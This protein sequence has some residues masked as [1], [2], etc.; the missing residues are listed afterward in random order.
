MSSLALVDIP[1]GWEERRSERPIPLLEQVRGVRT[2]VK[3]TLEEGGHDLSLSLL[4]QAEKMRG[5]DQGSQLSYWKNLEKLKYHTLPVSSAELVREFFPHYNDA[6]WQETLQSLH[7]RLSLE[8]DIPTVFIKRA[9]HRVRVTYHPQRLE[10]EITY[11]NCVRKQDSYEGGRVDHRVEEKDVGTLLA[12]NYPQEKW[13][14]LTFK[15]N[16][17]SF[18]VIRDGENIYYLGCNFV[19]AGNWL[20]GG[21]RPKVLVKTNSR[22]IAE[23]LKGYRT[24]VENIDRGKWRNLSPELQKIFRDNVAANLF[25]EI[26]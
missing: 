3:D 17:S 11:L 12:L 9:Y 25:A 24:I 22:L 4:D 21:H 8:L 15:D 16:W 13:R 6:Q 7:Q 2:E 20:D 10:Y 26:R 23:E 14:D 5:T 1:G 19:L 18:I